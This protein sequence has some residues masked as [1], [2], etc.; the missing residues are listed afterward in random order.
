MVY[1]IHFLH[2]NVEIEKVVYKNENVVDSPDEVVT[3]TECVIQDESQ[4]CAPENAPVKSSITK[5][6]EVCIQLPVFRIFVA[7]KVETFK[8]A[9]IRCMLLHKF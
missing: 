1:F 3:E 4:L 7:P 9:H 8:I 2:R 5:P 6:K